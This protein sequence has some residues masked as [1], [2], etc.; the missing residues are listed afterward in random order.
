MTRL[1]RKCFF[2]SVGLH[3]LLVAVLIL[4]AAFLVTQP[5]KVAPVLS[6]IAP[7]I[8]DDLLSPSTPPQTKPN[9]NQPSATRH[10]E[11]TPPRPPV[12][13]VVQPPVVTPPKPPKVQP[14]PRPTNPKPNRPK[15]P[16]ST[17]KKP[18][19]I[20]VNIGNT[21]NH[22]NKTRPNP[23]RPVKPAINAK[24]VNTALK[25][26]NN[27]SAKIK[28]QVSGSNRAAFATYAQ[29]VVAVYRRAWQPLIPKNLARTRIAEVS[30]TIDRT[31][32]VIS[33]R[34]IRRTGDA[35][36]DKSVQRALDKVRSVGKSFPSGSRDAKRTFI[37]DFT[38]IIGG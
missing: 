3:V 31:G 20:K 4:G 9:I 10:S 30:V 32:R 19:D 33:A 14:K 25:G 1:L 21:K 36:L 29:H 28:V 5:E 18:S 6:M 26:L 38:P 17:A 15:K 8:L 22:T 35:A 23:P 37:L 13:P 7:K 34:I 27:L 16:K 2:L 12:K 24:D 11:V